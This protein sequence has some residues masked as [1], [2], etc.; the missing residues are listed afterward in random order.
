MQEILCVCVCSGLWWYAS[1]FLHFWVRKLTVQGMVEGFKG[2]VLLIS[3]TSSIYALHS[4]STIQSYIRF[5]RGTK[6]G[7]KFL[8]SLSSPRATWQSISNLEFEALFLEFI[9]FH[10]VFF[11]LFRVVFDMAEVLQHAVTSD[12]IN[13]TFIIRMSKKPLKM[14]T[15]R[16]ASHDVYVLTK[17]LITFWVT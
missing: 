6:M 5:S 9:N 4:W 16:H 13:L 14:E 8:S 11:L 7:E 1:F 2:Q 17:H 3:I 12:G 15:W 10:R